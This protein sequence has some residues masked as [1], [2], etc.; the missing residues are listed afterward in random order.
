MALGGGRS[1]PIS[2]GSCALWF[3]AGRH[4]G[5]GPQAMKSVLL[6]GSPRAKARDPWCSTALDKKPS[7]VGEDA[8]QMTLS[9]RV[10][11]LLSTVPLLTTKVI[12]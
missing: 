9:S 8:Y 7:L 6:Y 11:V 5:L 3:Q 1:C 4:T 2:M 12:T 10:T